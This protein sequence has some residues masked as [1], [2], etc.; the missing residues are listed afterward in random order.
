[1]PPTAPSPALVY[2][3]IDVS[4]AE[5]VLDTRPASAPWTA[6]NDAIGIRGV[7]S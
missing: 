6:P 2:V 4:Q 3:G 1:M 7:A 5:L